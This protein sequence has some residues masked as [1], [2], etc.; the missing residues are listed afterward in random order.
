[1]SGQS[2][3]SE[4]SYSA[5]PHQAAFDDAFAGR[6]AELLH[7]PDQAIRTIGARLA[8]CMACNAISGGMNRN[9]CSFCE[10]NM[11][12]AVPLRASQKVVLPAHS[13]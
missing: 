13:I 10:A 6:V 3:S 11:A 1:M 9:N 5:F 8:A 12:S 2:V 7:H 4:I